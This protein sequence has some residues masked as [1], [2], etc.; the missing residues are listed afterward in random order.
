MIWEIFL[1]YIRYL[2]LYKEYEEKVDKLK[3]EGKVKLLLKIVFKAIEGWVIEGW[4]K[5][6]VYIFIFFIL[7]CRVWFKIYGIYVDFNI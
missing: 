1:D 6:Y 7:C 3:K 5:F 2:F 4:K